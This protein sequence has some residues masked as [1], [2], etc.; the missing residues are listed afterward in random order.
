[1]T[2]NLTKM[3]VRNVLHISLYILFLFAFSLSAQDFGK[4][5]KGNVKAEKIEKIEI[6]TP[7]QFYEHFKSKFLKAKLLRV[8]ENLDTDNPDDMQ[9]LYDMRHDNHE[10]GFLD[11][12]ITDSNSYNLTFGEN[13][14]HIV[15]YDSNLFLTYT[16]DANEALAYVEDFR[17]IKEKEEDPIY[18][19]KSFIIDPELRKSIGGFKL[20]IVDLNVKYEPIL[21]G[22]RKGNSTTYLARQMP[23]RKI[24][25][26]NDQVASSFQFVLPRLKVEFYN[27]NFV[28]LSEF[29]TLTE[30]VTVVFPK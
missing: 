29:D 19:N 25:Q 6:K 9:M 4:K 22:N 12:T 3:N 11:F 16:F 17:F 18:K 2:Q 20:K 27:S 24:Q 28:I 14:N 8:F 13:I 1:M 21:A 26:L 7:E 23:F 10:H 5:E 30:N 15:K